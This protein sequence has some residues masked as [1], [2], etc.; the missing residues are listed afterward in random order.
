M[1][2]VHCSPDVNKLANINKVNKMEIQQQQPRPQKIPI[3]TCKHGKLLSS[4]RDLTGVSIQ[5][6]ISMYCIV[7]A[8]CFI[9]ITESF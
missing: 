3:T 6:I 5:N 7:S 9:L 8:Q 2:Q 1:S 4:V